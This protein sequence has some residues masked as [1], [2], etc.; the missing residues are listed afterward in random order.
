MLPPTRRQTLRESPAPAVYSTGRPLQPS[1]AASTPHILTAQ[2]ARRDSKRRQRPQSRALTAH[3]LKARTAGTVSRATSQRTQLPSCPR[4]ALRRPPRTRLHAASHA[5]ARAQACAPIICPRSLSVLL[6]LLSHAHHSSASP[7]PPH[8]PRSIPTVYPRNTSPVRFPHLVA[9]HEPQPLPPAAPPQAQLR[10]VVHRHLPHARSAR[11]APARPSI[12]HFHHKGQW[13]EGREGRGGGWRQRVKGE[14]RGGGR[15][16]RRRG[17]GPAS[18][19][20][21]SHVYT[22]RINAIAYSRSPSDRASPQGGAATGVSDRV[23]QGGPGYAR[24]RGWAA[25]RPPLHK[26]RIP[27]VPG[28]IEGLGLREAPAPDDGTLP[29]CSR[30]QGAHH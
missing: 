6:P 27:L 13:I 24:E 20:E 4:T 7:P 15:R 3:R 8:R 16:G 2:T 26:V 5:H 9:G 21:W 11:P 1:P 23:R 25:D 29:P 18:E 12:T 30:P 19:G 14:S 17:G 22:H 10:V 28:T